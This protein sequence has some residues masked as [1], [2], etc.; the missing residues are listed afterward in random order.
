[1]TDEDVKKITKALFSR[2]SEDLAK[3]NN[4]LE[5]LSED[6]GKHT[7]KLDT[8]W[9]QTVKLTG[10]ITEV[11]ETLDSHT[12]ALK[13]IVTNTEHNKDNIVRL[14]KRVIETERHLGIVPSPESNII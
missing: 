8:L 11:Q 7:K 5:T 4:R 1:M 9:E 14:D 2:I 6:S 12:S 13:Q 10:D 3:I